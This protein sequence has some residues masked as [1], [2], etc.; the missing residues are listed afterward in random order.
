MDVSLN[1]SGGGSYMLESMGAKSYGF[2]TPKIPQIPQKPQVP[3]PS[4]SPA[5]PAPITPTRFTLDAKD[6][7]DRTIGVFIAV[8]SG[9]VE[10]AEKV[11]EQL[12]KEL[13]PKVVGSLS[14]EKQAMLYYFVQRLAAYGLKFG[15][16]LFLAG[17]SAK[18]GVAHSVKSLVS[19][20]W[21]NLILKE[22][23]KPYAA[24]VAAG[25][26]GREYILWKFGK[27]SRPSS[28]E[29]SLVA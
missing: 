24:D 12:K 17:T 25:Q 14:D 15:A 8:T 13:T 29:W 28:G 10:E 9:K 23:G 11:F 5:T 16:L 1:R 27:A 26:D 4:V 19:S 18:F 20:A 2:P 6:L 3:I 21:M 22:I 7:V